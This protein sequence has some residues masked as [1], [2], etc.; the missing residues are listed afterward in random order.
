[1]DRLGERG[2][3]NQRGS[4]FIQRDDLAHLAEELIERDVVNIGN[5][6]AIAL[7]DEKVNAYKKALSDMP[8]D[9]ALRHQFE[10]EITALQDK[11]SQLGKL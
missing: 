11:Q 8:P 9:G 6:A 4:A 5:K 1:M 7:L 2:C 10:R 3:R